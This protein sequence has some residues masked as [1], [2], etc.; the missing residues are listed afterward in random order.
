MATTDRTVEAM[1]SAGATADMAAAACTRDSMAGWPVRA[2]RVG[3]VALGDDHLR[4]VR[5]DS[6]QIGGTAFDEI[7]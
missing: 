5:R 3:F 4:G 6:C 7:T 1:S 2:L